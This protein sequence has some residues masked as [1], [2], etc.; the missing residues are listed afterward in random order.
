MNKQNTVILIGGID[1]SNDQAIGGE[2]IKNR[3][4]IKRF[5]E[6]FD[7]VV[8]VDTANWKKKPWLLFELLL[9]LLWY[10]KA[11]V[12]ISCA[13]FSAKKL[14]SL[15]YYINHSRSVTMWV[16]G[17]AFVDYVKE[18]VFTI[19]QLSWLNRI[20]VQ[21]QSM[22]EDAAKLGLHNVEYVPNSKPI[23]YHSDNIVLKSE[24]DKFRFVFLSRI[25]QEKGVR[26]ILDACR[27]LDEKG[28][29]NYYVGFYGK[30]AQSFEN[31]FCEA[32]A[33]RNNLEYLNYLNLSSREGYQKLSSFDI[34]LFPTYWKGEGFPGVLVDAFIAGL[35]VIATKHNLND[36]VVTDGVTGILVPTHDSQALANAMLKMMSNRNIL[37]SYRK[38]CVE[39]AKKYDYR[40][41]LS[42]EL[43][44]KIKLL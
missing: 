28:V 4:F 15:L 7:K 1:E 12:V 44:C 21:G 26:E 16:V 40:F 30:I 22:V 3:L 10:Y 6:V 13:S 41:V 39:E 5:R 43:F 27:I 36:T 31:E 25:D 24:S 35:P 20:V 9:K 18:G 38:N 19:K 14:I 23:I 17:G 42:E 8:T 29:N 34:M 11:K 32:I 37:L 33:E 2:I